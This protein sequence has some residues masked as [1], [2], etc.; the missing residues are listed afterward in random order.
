MSVAVG[1]QPTVCDG[2]R[3][4]SINGRG[5]GTATTDDLLGD[6]VGAG[7]SDGCGVAE[8]GDRSQRFSES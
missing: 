5:T 4:S 7:V 3:T 1:V 6:D 8:A 2:N